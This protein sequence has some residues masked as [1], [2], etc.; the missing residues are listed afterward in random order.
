MEMV[1]PPGIIAASG[2][3]HFGGFG[4]VEITMTVPGAIVP[5]F[6]PKG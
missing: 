2:T 4:P 5:G 1:D 3:R 6:G